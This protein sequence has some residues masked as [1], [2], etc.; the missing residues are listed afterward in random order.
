MKNNQPLLQCIA[1]LVPLY[2]FICI[3]TYSLPKYI[4]Q[5]LF[6]SY[7]GFSDNI[8]HTFERRKRQSDYRNGQSEEIKKYYTQTKKGCCF[9]FYT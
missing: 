1:I 2:F 9:L 6:Q 5:D 8:N 7:T 4:S 3:K